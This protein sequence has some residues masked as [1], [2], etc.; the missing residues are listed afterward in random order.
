[1]AGGTI[2][3]PA[4]SLAL[5]SVEDHREGCREYGQPH[6][7]SERMRNQYSWMQLYEN[8]V[9]DSNGH[10]GNYP[11]RERKLEGRK[12]TVQPQSVH[13]EQKRAR[14]EDG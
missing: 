10:G 7:P 13:E 3:C 6:E 4:N 1:M 11:N 9:S 5:S 2:R 8:E 14:H 12:K